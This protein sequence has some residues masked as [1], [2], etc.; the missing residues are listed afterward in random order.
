MQRH[1][2]HRPFSIVVVSEG[3]APVPGTMDVPDYPLDPNGWP[4][5]GGIGGL[6]A[7]ELARRTGYESRITVLGHVQRGGSPVAYDRVLATRL[8]VAA[9]DEAVAGG[10][11]RLVGVVGERLVTTP[12]AEA[13][14]RGPGRPR[15]AL[16]DP[17]GPLRLRPHG[18]RWGGA[19][20]VGFRP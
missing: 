9:V 12:I 14:T 2:E 18:P 1:R 7:T 4:R 8:G 11:G 10:W 6:V 13:G 5:L 20:V 15:G 17:A 3:A 16:A 19:P